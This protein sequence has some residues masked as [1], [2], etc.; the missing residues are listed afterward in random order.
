MKNLMAKARTVED[1]YLIFMTVNGEWEW[2]VLKSYQGDDFKPYAR[3]YCAT[4]SPLNFGRWEYGDVYC[5][6]VREHGIDVTEEVRAAE[7]LVK[8]ALTKTGKPI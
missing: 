1:P 6:T 8:E 7:K 4:R 3:W 2:R 5:D